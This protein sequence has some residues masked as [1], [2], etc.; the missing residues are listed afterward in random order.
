M[1][2]STLS[3]V[4]PKTV[5]IENSHPPSRFLLDVNTMGGPR[6]IASLGQERD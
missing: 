6:E 2:R 3:D 4:T 5:I 1:Y